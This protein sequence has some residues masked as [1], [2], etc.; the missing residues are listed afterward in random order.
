[1]NDTVPVNP[2]SEQAPPVEKFCPE[3]SLSR[4]PLSVPYLSKNCHCG[5][6]VHFI[7]R[8]ENGEGLQVR[9]GESLTIPNGAMIFSLENK[10]RGGMFRPGLPF[11]LNK[12]FVGQMPSMGDFAK[13]VQDTE[14]SLDATLAATKAGAGIDFATEAGAQEFVDRHGKESQSAEWYMFVTSVYSN[15]L[16]AALKKDDTLK[17]AYAGYSMGTYRGLSI[18]SEQVFEETIWRGY[19]ANGIIADADAA[20]GNRSPA[21]KEA[22]AR[23]EPLF[24]RLDDVTLSNLAESGLPI[25]PRINVAKLPEEILL[26]TAKHHVLIRERKRLALIEARK[27]DIAE[28][29]VM[30]KAYAAGVAL[31]ALVVT[32]GVTLWINSKK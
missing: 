1:M 25:G 15:L 31:L 24:E 10:G 14:S 23:L 12:V 21:E 27:L 13:Y 9:E 18:V 3:C 22:L 20:V 17:A 19:L 5:R 2:A 16:T 11:F 4:F 6:T 32:A 8:D 29:D 7:R 26:A 28:Q 30:M